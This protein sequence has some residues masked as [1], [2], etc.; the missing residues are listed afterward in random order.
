MHAQVVVADVVA[1]LEEQR[2]GI[3]GN[4]VGAVDGNIGYGNGACARRLYVDDVVA[5]CRDGY[6]LEVGQLVK[7]ISR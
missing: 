7:D 5:G 4:G 2:E 3:L 6:E 1:Q